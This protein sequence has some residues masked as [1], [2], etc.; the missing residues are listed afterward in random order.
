MN[1]FLLFIISIRVVIA[2]CRLL[3]F[4]KIFVVDLHILSHHQLQLIYVHVLYIDGTVYVRVFVIICSA[5][6]D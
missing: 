4:F 1:I 5:V 6:S 3:R 2:R